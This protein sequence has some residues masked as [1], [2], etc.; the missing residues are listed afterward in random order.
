MSSRRSFLGKS[1]LSAAGMIT[2][3]RQLHLPDALQTAST[4]PLVISTWNFG[5]PANEAA[6]KVIEQ[7]GSALD[8]VESGVMIVEAD[9]E[10][11]SVGRGGFPDAAGDVTLDASIMDHRGQC[12]AVAC[13][14]KTLHPISV[15]RAVMERTQH[16]LLVGEKA[17]DFATQIGF[18]K[19]GL[20]TPNARK[21]W[22]AWKANNPKWRSFST[23]ISNHDTIG[24]LA[25]DKQGNLSGAC[26]T[27]GWAF[28]IPGRVGD[29]PIIGA[30]LYVDNEIGAA[31]AT[32]TG[33][34]VI[35]ICGSFLVVE[36]M[37]QGYSPQRAC[38][39]AVSRIKKRNPGNPE[40]FVGFIA[41]NKS[42]E[43]GAFATKTGFEYALYQ[44][45][46]NRLIPGLF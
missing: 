11:T 23:D 4:D 45:G 9:P 30:G 41:I 43:H 24:M 32:G 42:G 15:A 6:M 7:G 3:S 36:L 1:L 13:L 33:E 18:P 21:A 39:E 20:L 8:A 46:Q 37:R 16:V 19:T 40:L 27:S 17:R 26:T 14:E 38:E 44:H 12:G 22:K 34:E 2:A 28:K 25:I 35:K 31:T 10:S 5:I 29:S